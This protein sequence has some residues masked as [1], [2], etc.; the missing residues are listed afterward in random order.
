VTTVKG[1]D[2]P[3]VPGS[4]LKLWMRELIYPIVPTELYDLAIESASKEDPQLAV[5]L[6]KD[7]PVL[8]RRVLYYVIQ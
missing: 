1:V 5:Q 4:L 3:H 7:M 2:D 8:N 6:V